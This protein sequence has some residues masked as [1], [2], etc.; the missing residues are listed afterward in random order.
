MDDRKKKIAKIVLLIVLFTTIAGLG[1]YLASRFLKSKN[2]DS[3]DDELE[4]ALAKSAMSGSQGSSSQAS[5]AKEQ[6]KK[7]Q[8]LLL[9]IGIN[10]N[11]NEIIDAIQ[12]TGGI[13]GIMGDGF[14]LA[15]SVAIENGYIESLDDLRNRVS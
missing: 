13:D 11:N 4:I 9:N 12:L 8:A 2:E 5:S 3:K 7:M 10:N 1:I 15:L 6:I 14:N